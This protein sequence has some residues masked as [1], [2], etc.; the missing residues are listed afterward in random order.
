PLW[1]RIRYPQRRLSKDIVYAGTTLRQTNHIGDSVAS[2]E[3]QF[4]VTA[5]GFSTIDLIVRSLPLREGFR[6]TLPLYSEGDD[7]LEVDT[8]AVLR[9][10]GGGRYTVRFSDAVIIQTYVVDS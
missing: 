6:A 4:P 7:C 8:V 5:F 2:F 1:E 3:R 10:D 9:R